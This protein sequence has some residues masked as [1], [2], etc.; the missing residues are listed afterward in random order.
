MNAAAGV[1]GPALSVYAVATRWPQVAFA[2]TAQPY[3]VVIGVAS[4]VGKFVATG[5]AAP[6]LDT[7]AWPI[8]IAALVVGLA[9]GE[10]LSPRISHRV[11]RIAVIA[12]AYVGGAAALVDGLVDLAG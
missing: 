9:I 1:G 4:L 11:A 2:A 3:F 5:W 7:A 8:V 10:F 6:A 12:I